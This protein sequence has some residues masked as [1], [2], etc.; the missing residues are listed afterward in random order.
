MNMPVTNEILETVKQYNAISNLH[1]KK[2][3]ELKTNS[4]NKLHKALYREVRKEFP[5]LNDGS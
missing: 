4:K 1:I 3:F 2:C 5:K